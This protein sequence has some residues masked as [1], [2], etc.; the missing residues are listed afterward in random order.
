MSSPIT[1]NHDIINLML[2]LNPEEVN[3]SYI[4]SAKT[5]IF[6]CSLL[7]SHLLVQSGLSTYDLSTD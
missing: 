1:E 5:P 3:M 4:S 6:C 7:D 2:S